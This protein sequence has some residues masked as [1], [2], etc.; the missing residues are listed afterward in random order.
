[1]NYIGITIGPVYQVLQQCRKTRHVWG[2]SY[3]FS[4][5]MKQVLLQLQARIPDFDR[6]YL[7]LPAPAAQP[8][9]GAGI[10]PDQLVLRHNNE[11]ALFTQVTGA[12][13]AARQILL[14]PLSPAQRQFVSAVIKIYTAEITTTSNDPLREITQQLQW[15]DLQQ[16]YNAHLLT[17][18]ITWPDII[19]KLNGALFFKEANT[20]TPFP[21]VNKIAAAPLHHLSAFKAE[22]ED[23]AEQENWY[24]LLRTQL[25]QKDEA[26]HNVYK[27]IAV[28]T[29]DGDRIGATLTKAG[30]DQ[31]IVRE[32]AATLTAFTTQA[33]GIVQQ[34]G[35]LAVYAGGDD[36]KCFTP[37]AR[38]HET[39]H[40]TVFELIH[41]LHQC[42]TQTLQDSKILTA[43]YQQHPALLQPTLSFGLHISYYK[44]PLNEAIAQAE[45]NL[46]QAKNKYGRNAVV[47][48]VRKHS[49]HHFTGLLDGKQPA[50]YKDLYQ[51]L[52]Y[53]TPQN[54]FLSSI[55][56][57]LYLYR[58]LFAVIQYDP[59]RM[60][61]FIRNSYNEDIHDTRRD[62]LD[63]VTQTIARSAAS[64]SPGLEAMQTDA[65]VY[66]PRPRN[67]ALNIVYSALR[68]IHFVND[69]QDE[70]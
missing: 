66:E 30:A 16:E 13:E 63:T 54:D 67:D 44:Y 17:D 1:M 41:A 64:P 3:C 28:L 53:T 37:V 27:Y 49:G 31:S 15:L 65:P 55:M 35:G 48:S 51:L 62:F 46:W 8:V 59:V 23:D 14:Q 61:R 45:D 52:Q 47:W 10:T 22:T 68:F 56:H 5:L 50:L 32:M 24:A 42:F 25:K 58:K 36:I 2:A 70:R 34:W 20:A 9:K 6:Q 7:L 21:S 29:A 40:Q 33:V 38:P 12:I 69:T 11:P 26:F 43:F 19:D 4:F 18:G 60:A 57:N 39:G